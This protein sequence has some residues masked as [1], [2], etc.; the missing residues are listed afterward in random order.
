LR[1]HLSP[2]AS[3]TCPSFWN[4]LWSHPLCKT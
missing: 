1:S 2:I 4:L 3:G